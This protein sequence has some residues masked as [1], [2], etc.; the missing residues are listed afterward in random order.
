[1]AITAHLGYT[2]GVLAEQFNE[3]VNEG[4]LQEGHIAGGKIGGVGPAAQR[5]QASDQPLK[6]SASALGIAHNI[7]AGR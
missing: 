7:D 6:G 3:S 1:M 5:L 2:N 4:G